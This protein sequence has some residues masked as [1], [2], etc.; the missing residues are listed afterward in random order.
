MKI[1]IPSL[2]TRIVLTRPWVFK[3]YEEYRNRTLLDRFNLT[4]PP[5]YNHWTLKET[6]CY[7]VALPIGTVLTVDRVYIRQGQ[8]EFDSV[9]FWVQ[10]TD[11]PGQQATTNIKKQRFWAKLKDVNNIEGNE[12]LPIQNLNNE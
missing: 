7:D 9:S 8:G 11:K 12:I 6:L 1:N 4:P 5:K 10:I 2:G 3:L